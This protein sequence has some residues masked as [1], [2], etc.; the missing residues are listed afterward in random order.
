MTLEEQE[1]QRAEWQEVSVQFWMGL[2]LGK[3]STGEMSGR[4]LF[5]EYIS[6]MARA[7][8]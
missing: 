2:F 1:R 3:F 8:T 6:T 7:K 5:C 4:L